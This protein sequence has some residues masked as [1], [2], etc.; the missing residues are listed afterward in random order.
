MLR[1]RPIRSAWTS[2]KQNGLAPI[3]L[4]GLA[5]APL[6]YLLADDVPGNVPPAAIEALE[7]EAWRSAVQKISPSVVRIETLGGEASVA[8][9]DDFTTAPTTGIV[10]DEG[11][12]ILT[13]AL[14]FASTP[15][16]ILVT[17]PSG[18]RKAA[19][20]VAR[21]RS[22]ELVLLRVKTDQKLVVPEMVSRDSLRIGQSVIAVG[23]TL[24]PNQPTMS[25]GIVSAKDRVFG[26]AIQTD[27]KISPLNYGGPLIDLQGR[28][29]GILSPLA[30]QGGEGGQTGADWYDIGLGFAVPLDEIKSRLSV[31]ERGVDLMPGLLGISLSRGDMYSLPAEIIGCRL[32]GPAG[33]AGLKSKDV[34]IEVDGQPIVR[35]AQL[36]HAVGRK[37]AGEA[38]QIVV[39]RG[40][41]R[42][43][44]SL[45]LVDKIEPYDHPFLG[46]LPIRGKRE[47]GGVEVRYVY[48][49]SPAANAGIEARDVILSCKGEK[50]QSI[51]QL[52]Q[53]LAPS[54]LKDELTLEVL[55]G[56]ET[57]VLKVVVGSLPSEV[58]ESLP[59]PA[60]PATAP[61]EKLAT[62]VLELKV[63]QQQAVAQVL[64]PQ[65]YDGQSSQG[66]IIWFYA[67]GEATAE[68][69]QSR[70][71]DFAAKHHCLVLAAPMSGGDKWVPDDLELVSR[72]VEAALK[73]Y[74]V[75]KARIVT[76]GRGP[77]GAA[78]SSAYVKAYL[79]QVHGM[80]LVE[81]PS[82]R[83]NQIVSSDQALRMAIFLANS[84]DAKVQQAQAANLKALQGAKLPVTVLEKEET[85]EVDLQGS[86]LDTLGRWIDSLDRL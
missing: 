79:D 51:E 64:V 61:A 6:S 47:G 58:P 39:K 40:D 69:I 26:K 80:V 11:G 18:E 67:A 41:E 4:G 35:Q 54:T 49:A 5:L 66:L 60:L 73:D 71:G 48:K 21:D 13:S 25:L 19:E 76:Y 8:G 9:K 53:L 31:L 72:Y 3:V 15:P 7:E 45:V 29:V 83:F 34:I 77:E 50:L 86:D 63:P 55:R 2:F 56:N 81:S 65:G 10:I 43:E 28:V 70:F 82:L 32:D 33:K 59:P 62:G 17:L 78:A 1:N 14:K 37:Y 57:K 75:D 85:K 46:I 44:K 30:A 42:I 38:I 22:R 27:A 24:E 20:L 16:S 23:M 12:L 84:K 52:Y 68:K 36:K 74:N